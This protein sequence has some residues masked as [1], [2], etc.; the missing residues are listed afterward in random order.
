M[1]QVPLVAVD[2][3]GTAVMLA[4]AAVAAGVA[5]ERFARRDLQTG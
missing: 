5:V 2:R 1:T 4:V 3:R